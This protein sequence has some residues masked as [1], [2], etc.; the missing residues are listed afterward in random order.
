MEQSCTISNPVAQDYD[1]DGFVVVP[2]LFSG[3]QC[4]RLKEEA[5]RLLHEKSDRKRTVY[6][7]VAAASQ[8]YYQFASDP[9]MV[10]ILEKIMP[11]GIEFMSDKFVFKSGEQHF[12]TPWHIDAFYWAN[13]RP[14][15]SVWIALDKVS[16][17]NGALKVIRGSHKKAW[18]AKNVKGEGTNGEFGNVIDSE[19]WTPGEEV[20][21]EVDKG[22]AIFFSDKLVHGSCT[23]TSGLDRYAII[24][25]YHAPVAVPEEF[26]KQFPAKHVIRK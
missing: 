4:E 20:V 14:K 18:R 2:K 11:E 25:T 21:C 16:A 12:A 6:V 26:D 8:L 9:K 5:L 1:R 7:G 17:E 10:A 3:E 15:L 24:S 19:Q 13:T 23:N 22:S